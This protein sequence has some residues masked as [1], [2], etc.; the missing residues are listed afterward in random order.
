MDVN[1]RLKIVGFFLTLSEW[2]R[3]L[4]IIRQV[5]NSIDNFEPYA[6]FLRLTRG[7][8]PV[9]EPMDIHNFVVENGFRGDMTAEMV[10]VRIFDTTFECCLDF[11]DFLKMILSRDNPDIRFDAAAKREV[12]EVEDGQKLSEEIEYSLARF[13]HKAASFLAR[14]MSDQETQAILEESGLYRTITRLSGARTLDFNGLRSF[15]EE[16][17]V[18]PQ[19]VE[20]IGILRLIDINDDGKI[21]DTEFTYF[22]ELFSG[23]EPS[24]IVLKSLVDSRKKEQKYNYFGE[25]AHQDVPDSDQNINK[26]AH[27]FSPDFAQKRAKRKVETPDYMLDVEEAKGYQSQAVRP[28]RRYSSIREDN[29]RSPYSYHSRNSRISN[30]R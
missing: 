10:L 5:L 2:D 27:S 30:N 6:A 3:H 23:K 20:I 14:M 7:K 1:R 9:I 22:V 25:V 28:S 16:A 29:I 15:F 8:K 13:F 18:I 26:F 19:D 21:D 24:N 11:E 4:E 12:Y 17:K